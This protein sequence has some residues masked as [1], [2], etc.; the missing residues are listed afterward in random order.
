MFGLTAVGW[1][2]LT[3]EERVAWCRR[4]KSQKTRRRLG[5]AWPLPGFNYYM[6]ENV[7]LVNRGQPQLAQPPVESREPRPDLPLL[8]RTLSPQELQLLTVSAQTPPE[9]PGP[10][11][12]SSG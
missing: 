3:E 7:F 4:G 11:P 1:R 9:S 2:F 5:Q 10:A 6:R 8:T 12:P